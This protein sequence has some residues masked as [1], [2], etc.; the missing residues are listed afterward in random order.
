M[1][2]DRV[3]DDIVDEMG[4]LNSIV[5]LSSGDLAQNGLFVSIRKLKR[6]TSFAVFLVCIGFLLILPT[7]D[8]PR[9]VLDWI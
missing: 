9:P 4:S 3:G 5:K 6:A 8:F 1:G 7:V 2:T